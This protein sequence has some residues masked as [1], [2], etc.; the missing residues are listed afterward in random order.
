VPFSLARAWLHS[1]LH[2]AFTQQCVWH[3]LL[4]LQWGVGPMAL[5][6]WREW[7]TQR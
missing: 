2:L 6:L 5:M 1:M 3:R 4:A 7:V